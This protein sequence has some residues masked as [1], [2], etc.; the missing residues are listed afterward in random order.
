MDKTNINAL[1][2]STE[3][4]L[5]LIYKKRFSVKQQKFKQIWPEFQSVKCISLK[6]LAIQTFWEPGLHEMVPLGLSTFSC[7]HNV[8]FRRRASSTAVVVSELRWWDCQ[9]FPLIPFIHLQISGLEMSA[10]QSLSD[11]LNPFQRCRGE[12][13]KLYT[14]GAEMAKSRCAGT[15]SYAKTTDLSGSIFSS[16]VPEKNRHST[17][18]SSSC[19]GKHFIGDIAMVIVKFRPR[20]PHTQRHALHSLSRPNHDF[21]PPRVHVQSQPST[22]TQWRSTA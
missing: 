13:H 11:N 12:K 22:N 18:Y 5:H 1:V 15:P 21:W 19:R 16:P 10:F 3:C 20:W 7:S 17:H 2:Q 4:S 14:Y 8:M 9:G 6:N